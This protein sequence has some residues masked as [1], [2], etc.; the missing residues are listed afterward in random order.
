[1]H[2]SLIAFRSLWDI[3]LFLASARTD[4]RLRKLRDA[5][6]VSAEAF[7]KLY[8][9]ATQNDPWSATVPRYRYQRRKYEGLLSLLPAGPFRQAADLGCGLGLLAERL[10]S[11]A[12]HVLGVDVSNVALEAAA[13]RTSAITNLKFQQGDIRALGAELDR[14]FDLV[15]IADTIYYLPP[16]I[17]DASLKAIADRVADILVPGGILMVANHYVGLP[18][19]ETRLT[20]RI[21]RAFQWS[22]KLEP[23][24]DHVGAFYLASLFRRYESN[25]PSGAASAEEATL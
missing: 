2:Y 6:M 22:P 19:T 14:R 23:I 10:S 17:L 4:F 9:D 20:Q 18:T 13:K 15:V 24:S 7:D 11:R 3:G 16:P 12:D 8:S 21:H 5:S 1:M 25:E